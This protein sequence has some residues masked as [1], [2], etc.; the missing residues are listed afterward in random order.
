M[1]PSSHTWSYSPQES[2]M[3]CF[4]LAAMSRLDANVV[5]DASVSR[6]EGFLTPMKYCTLGVP[7]AFEF[8]TCW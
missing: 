6:E 3:V 2:G 8:D 4:C 5:I 7:L 1:N